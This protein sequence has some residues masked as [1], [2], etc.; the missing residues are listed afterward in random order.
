MCPQDASKIDSKS[1]CERYNEMDQSHYLGLKA[2]KWDGKEGDKGFRGRNS[3]NNLESR[4]VQ[5]L[6]RS[7]VGFLEWY[8]K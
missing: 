6:A 2:S 3:R 5:T 8:Q 7:E 1:G 4:S